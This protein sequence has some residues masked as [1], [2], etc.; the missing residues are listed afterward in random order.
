MDDVTPPKLQRRKRRYSPRK[1]LTQWIEEARARQTDEGC[2]PWTG[3]LSKQGYPAAATNGKSPSVRSWEL[4]NGPVPEGLELD[5]ACHSKSACQ[6]GVNCLHRRCINPAHLRPMTREENQRLTAGHRR[7]RRGKMCTH[8]RTAEYGYVRPSGA[9]R[10]RP[11]HVAR[12]AAA[13]RRARN[14]L[15]LHIGLGD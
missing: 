1:P 5:H 8:P 11:C 4:V 9:W 14:L 3:L 13:K 10:C 15:D 7:D 6:E 2:W 12:K